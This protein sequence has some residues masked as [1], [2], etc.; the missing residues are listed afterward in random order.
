M[1]RAM[2]VVQTGVGPKGEDTNAPT[3]FLVDGSGQVRWNFRP[4]R[5]I[6]RLSPEE[7][8]NAIERAR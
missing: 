5:F 7:L 8:L 1:A 4:E 6:V 2:A 3:T